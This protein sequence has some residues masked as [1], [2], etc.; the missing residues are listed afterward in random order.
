MNNVNTLPEG[1]R[2]IYSLDIQKDKKVGWIINGFA[3]IIFIIV[4]II[5]LFIVPLSKM[6]DM[7][8]GLARYCLRFAIMFLGDI[9]YIILHEL[10]HGVVMKKY[11]AKKINYGFTG[12]YAYAGSDY[13]FNK[14]SY[15]VIALAPVVLWGVILAII[16]P[17][18]G[19]EWFWVV[20]FI[21]I[22]NLSGA[23]GDMYVVHKFR[24]MP[25]N[26]L[27]H[28]TGLAMKVYGNDS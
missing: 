5:G 2:E 10:I 17:F 18:V 19:E 22:T 12:M 23:A 13:Y 27:V 25:E 26:I 9:L 24:S 21:Q 3:I 1:Y 8:Q 28:D 4:M 7:E 14:K 16:N 6:F 11:G 15:L 20:Y